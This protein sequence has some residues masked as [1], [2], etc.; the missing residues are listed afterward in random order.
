MNVNDPKLLD[1]IGWD[2]IFADC[3]R[4][5]NRALID[6]LAD[7]TPPLTPEEVEANQS[8]VNYNDLSLTKALHSARTQFA[9][10]FLKT[11]NYFR[12]T[13]DAGSRD[14]R[15]Q[16]NTIVTEAI[17]KYLKRSV[18][19][20]ETYRSRIGSLCL[21]GIAPNV[22]EN[23]DKWCPRS[24]GVGDVLIP[25]GTLL[26]F[27]NLPFFYLRRSFT[28]IELM[29]ITQASKRDPGWNMP[30]V[31]RCLDWI[32]EQSTML[33]GNYWPDVYTPER[34]EQIIKES[35]GGAWANDRAP[36]VN[37]FDIYVWNE[38]GDEQGWVRRIIIDTWSSPTPTGSSYVLDRREDMKKL[39]SPDDKTEKPA[40]DQFLFTS[41]DRKV[42]RSWQEI[43]S[44]QFADLSAVAPFRY[45]SIR[46][47]GWLLYG[48]C[49]IQNRLNCKFSEAVFETLMQF[50]RVKSLDD[51]QRALKL[52]LF[53]RGFL[54]D[55][56][57]PIPAQERWQPN[58]PLVELMQQQ[59]RGM[60]D[61]GTGTYAQRTDYSPDKVEKTRFQVMAEV[62]ADSALVGAAL[63]QAYKYQ[64]YEDTE[65]LRRFLKPNSRDPDVRAFRN[66]VLRQGV[67]EKILTP[68]KWEAEHEQVMGGGSKTQELN[69]TQQLLQMYQLFDPSA[70]RQILRDATLAITDNAGRA[71]MLVPEQ[72][73]ISDSIHDTELAFGTLM[74]GS[75][76]TP[77]PGLNATEVA[78]TT[79]RLMAQKV[80]M[81]MQSGTPGTPQDLMGLQL[82][83]QYAG[84][85]MQ[86]LSQDPE[87][88]Q[89]V[90][91]LGD[92][93]GQI[94]NQIKAM[95][96]QQQE[97][98]Q[99]AAQ[100]NGN[101]QDPE[102][103][104]KIQAMLLQAQTKSENAKQSHAER[105]AQRQI[106]F[107]QKTRQDQQK[108]ALDLQTKAQQHALD[109]KTKAA[110][111]KLK[112]AK[113]RATAIIDIT[114]AR[115]KPT[116][117]SE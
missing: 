53:N 64:G 28:G 62:N 27:E 25:S 1:S 117:P 58:V 84:A 31:Q 6:G 103:M 102:A 95:A 69:A 45:H 56:V 73:T 61:S 34:T 37:T 83:A 41:G 12:C 24:L 114:K 20:F 106:T 75:T 49:V 16:Y 74:Q 10:G 90:K 29:K 68:E 63:S 60:I 55:S 17:N 44:F 3:A 21:H 85:F 50:F 9:N 110:D 96:Q 92:A 93:L 87:S 76:V 47:L 23:E 54:D 22:W 113:D 51:V 72:P 40:W 101:G 88:K 39:H 5:T 81:I 65:V 15:S 116:K 59:L 19:Y 26:G 43:M 46:S 108:Q 2:L 79:I 78:S 99:A 89:I 105:T 32:E 14:K 66:S 77:K 71:K 42:A 97:A 91:Q 18:P 52:N 13:T 107:E 80:Q 8:A 111:A 57:N 100:Q 48:V 38:E 104:A 86:Q 33:R 70:Q 11:G 35:N 30:F 94:M 7:G 67:P 36:V 98:A 82:A 115:S 109:L 112:I 4:S